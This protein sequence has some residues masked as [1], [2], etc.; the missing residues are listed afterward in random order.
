VL[1]LRCLSYCCPKRLH[2]SNLIREFGVSLG[3]VTHTVELSNIVVGDLP[4]KSGRRADYYLSFDCSHNPPIRTSVAEG[5]KPKVVHFPE[6]VTLR[7]R[8][9]RLESSLGITVY[10]L[11]LVG[12]NEMCSLK[13]RASNVINWSKK[14]PVETRR[15]AMREPK[16]EDMHD[17]E[18]GIRTPPWIAFDISAPKNDHRNLDRLADKT[19][20]RTTVMSRDSTGRFS[21]DYELRDLTVGNAKKEYEL[22]DPLG[23][24][25]TEPPEEDLGKLECYRDLVVLMFK[26]CSSCT[27]IFIIVVLVARSYL[28]LCTNQWRRIAMAVQIRPGEAPYSVRTLVDME[29]TCHER[30]E[31]TG[32]IAG[33]D[34]C[35][36]S[37]QQIIDVCDHPPENQPLPYAFGAIGQKLFSDGERH[38]LGF[39]C[40][41]SLC[42]L[43]DHIEHVDTAL[44]VVLSLLLFYVCCLLRPCA[45]MLIEKRKLA[46]A[47]AHR[48][49]MLH[50]KDVSRRELEEQQ[51]Y[52]LRQLPR[53]QYRDVQPQRSSFDR[54]W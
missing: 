15:F 2:G 20:V 52:H 10:K 6:V 21:G 31:G 32:T 41:Q 26:V 48:T 50:Q 42:D 7:I 16:E 37:M 18:L 9:N 51:L 43:H 25:V 29:K 33:E 47:R 36:P 19:I 28:G 8:N 24:I 46:A 39:V 35:R 17:A 5:K 38:N 27:T 45:N 14:L 22:L 30:M 3:L 40:Q 44:L 4:R 12:S 54:R 11:D 34:K 49:L 23:H 13:L 1:S 53:G